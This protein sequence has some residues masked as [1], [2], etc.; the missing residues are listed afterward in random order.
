MR[1]LRVEV[2][3]AIR[4]VTIFMLVLSFNLV[5]GLS[6]AAAGHQSEACRKHDAEVAAGKPACRVALTIGNND[7]KKG[8]RNAGNDGRLIATTLK[9]LGWDVVHEENLDRSG[10]IAALDGFRARVAALCPSDTVLF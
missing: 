1:S 2:I 5:T 8:I 10:M 9:D 6:V 3:M 7:P 4:C